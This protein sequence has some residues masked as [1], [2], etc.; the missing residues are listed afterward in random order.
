MGTRAAY[1]GATRKLAAVGLL[2]TAALGFT[3]CGTTGEEAGA[4]V[5]DVQQGEVVETTG[6]AADVA[7][8]AYAGPYDTDFYDEAVTYAGEEVTLSAQINEI[9]S[10]TA[11]TIAGTDDTTASPLLIITDQ[12]M[13]DLEEGRSVEV[14]GTVQEAFDLPQVEEEMEEDL[15]DDLFGDYDGQPYIQA[16]EVSTDVPAEG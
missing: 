8:G 10:P 14:T 16:T 3:A 2:S 7:A 9:I 6:P 13:P 4:D 12:Q 5:E 1:N 15:D 11:F